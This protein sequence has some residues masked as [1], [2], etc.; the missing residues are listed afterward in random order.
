MASDY[1]YPDT[2]DC[3]VEIAVGYE[4][5][6]GY[7]DQS[8]MII[9]EHVYKRLGAINLPCQDQSILDAGCGDGRLLKYFAPLFG[10]IVAID[11]DPVR[12]GRA[13]ETAKIEGFACKSNFENI[14]IEEYSKQHLYDFILCSHVIE[15]VHTLLLAKI[16]QSLRQLLSKKGVLLI[17][18]SHSRNMDEHFT[19]ITL[20]N[21]EHREEFISEIAFNI[22]TREKQLRCDTIVL[23][24]HKFT[25]KSLYRM[26]HRVG[27]KIDVFR[28]Y[29]ELDNFGDLD[30]HFHRDW[31]INLHRHLQ[32][33]YGHDMAAICSCSSK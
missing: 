12:L 3:C 28:V 9:L 14:S 30:N 4:P 18:T 20:H 8:E 5:Y 7:W 21:G 11:P 33:R 16:L 19:K 15:H 26:F 1:R 27:L 17:T 25:R 24:I 22:L 29:H 32:D 10:S 31:F 13:A 23:P 2:N 6:S